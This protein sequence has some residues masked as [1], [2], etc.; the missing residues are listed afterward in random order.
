MAFLIFRLTIIYSLYFKTYIIK[1]NFCLYFETDY[2]LCNLIFNS[3]FSL[4]LNTAFLFFKFPHTTTSLILH[5]IT[6]RAINRSFLHKLRSQ[7][8]TNHFLPYL[9]R[10]LRR[11]LPSLIFTSCV[12]VV[13]QLF[14]D[15]VF[16]LCRRLIS[17]S[18]VLLA[19]ILNSYFKIDRIGINFHANKVLAAAAQVLANTLTR[20]ATAIRLDAERRAKDTVGARKRAVEALELFCWRGC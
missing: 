10:T 11:T 5:A 18:F 3:T 19:A 2:Y 4:L 6:Y 17:L 1:C 9:F 20:S 8:T 15:L 14:I 13:L 16:F 12:S 7:T